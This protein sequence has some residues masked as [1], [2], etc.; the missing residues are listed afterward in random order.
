MLNYCVTLVIILISVTFNCYI[1]NITEF[2]IS[3]AYKL[4]LTIFSSFSS[5]LIKL[6]YN[7]LLH[8]ASLQL[9]LG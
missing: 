8:Q 9:E 5:I 3:K 7:W 4:E 6:F 1:F 2:S